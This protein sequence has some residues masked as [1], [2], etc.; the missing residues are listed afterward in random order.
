MVEIVRNKACHTFYL[1]SVK[2]FGNEIFWGLWRS[3]PRYECFLQINVTEKKE[4]LLL[5]IVKY[6]LQ[7]V[8]WSNLSMAFEIRAVPATVFSHLYQLRIAWF[9]DFVKEYARP[10]KLFYTLSTFHNG[11]R[12]SAWQIYHQ[13][14]SKTFYKSFSSFDY[15]TL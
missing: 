15:G 11:I 5:W 4:I 13:T 10:F 6:I 2:V 1:E 12:Q 8:N 3:C 9:W 7:I 14:L